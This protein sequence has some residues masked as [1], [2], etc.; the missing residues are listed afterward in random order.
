MIPTDNFELSPTT[1]AEIKKVFNAIKKQNSSGVD[2]LSL[3]IFKNLPEEALM[4]LVTCINDSF[5]AGEFPDCL[6]LAVVVPIFK[7][8]DD[9]D[10]SN[11]RP[12]S[13]LTTLSKI[14]EKIV[15]IRL[16]EYLRTKDIITPEQF[17]F[18]EEERTQDAISHF[19]KSFSSALMMAKRRRRCSVI[20]PKHLIA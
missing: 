9:Q 3:K 16:V 15:K 19:W 14:I 8:G 6:K 10:P 18:Q 20:F 13:L 5:V 17:G 11:Y 1:I 7:G 4:A 2:N 12:I